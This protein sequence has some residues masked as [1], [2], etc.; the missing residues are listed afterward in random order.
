VPAQDDA[1]C[2][3]DAGRPPHFYACIGGELPAPCV[4]NSIGNLTNTFCC[5]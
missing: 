4:V 3:G 1:Q 2:G 5:P